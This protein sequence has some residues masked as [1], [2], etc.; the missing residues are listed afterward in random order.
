[1]SRTKGT[2]LLR[3]AHFSDFHIGREGADLGTDLDQ[4]CALI[5]HAI[6]AGA[7]HVLFGGDIVDHGN[8]EDCKA[9]RA[10]LQARFFLS[11][12]RFSFVPGNHDIWP[13]GED[14]I[15]EGAVNWLAGNLRALVTADAWPAQARY[16]KLSEMFQESFEGAV[17]LSDSDPFPAFKR[18]G[19]LGLAM[20]DTT[21]DL[22]AFASASGRFER[23]EAKWLK[24][25]AR[26]HGGPSLL[27][28]HHW[29]F[30]AEIDFDAESLPWLVRKPLEAFGVDPAQFVDVNFQELAKVR[31]FILHGPFNAV[32]CGHIHVMSDDP[33][34]AEFDQKIGKVP[35]HCMGRSGGVHQDADEAW[36]GYHLVDVY[37]AKVAVETVLIQ[38]AELR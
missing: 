16:E 38:A 9:L 29:P 21:S 20:L 14:A 11:G 3:L 4:M 19:P 25:A 5:D 8:V 31:R 30:Q 2:R 17:H 22:G 26:E 15:G 28:M 7:Q 13:F 27:L 36:L 34:D 18:I 37:S 10:H 24:E 1:M 35:I 32:L 6:S 23:E 33:E 12:E